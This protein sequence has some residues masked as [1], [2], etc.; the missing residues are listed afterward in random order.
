MTGGVEAPCGALAQVQKRRTKVVRLKSHRPNN[1]NPTIIQNRSESGYGKRALPVVFFSS[2]RLRSGR[3]NYR[4]N[5][6]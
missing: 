1:T 4:E 3:A 5:E 6:R 2:F